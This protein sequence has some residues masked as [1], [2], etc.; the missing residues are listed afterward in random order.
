MIFF[1]PPV[2]QPTLSILNALLRTVNT[3][4]LKSKLTINLLSFAL[5]CPNYQHIKRRQKRKSRVQD[6]NNNKKKNSI[7]M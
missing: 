4:G 2:P 6:N 3:F 1:F 5:K 7:K